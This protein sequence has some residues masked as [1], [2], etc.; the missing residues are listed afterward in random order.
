MKSLRIKI[1]FFMLLC[2]LVTSCIVSTL[3]IF[4]INYICNQDAVHIM[5]L[6]IQKKGSEINTLTSSIEQSVDILAHIAEAALTDLNTFQSSPT[7]VD[8][9]T[10]SLKPIAEQFAR[11]TKGASNV[12]IRYN[13]EFTEPT[14]GLFLVKNDNDTFEETIPVN[15]T[16]YSKTDT[17]HSAWYYIPTE[18][19]SATW[20]KPYYN[21]N[22]DAYYVTYVTP[23]YKNDTL[24]GVVG[25]DIDFSVIQEIID[26][27]PLYEGGYA[28]LINDDSTI[29]DHP[30]LEFN[31]SLDSEAYN[32]LNAALSESAATTTPTQYTYDNVNK[33][34]VYNPL[35]SGLSLVISA[36][37]ASIYQNLIKIILITLVATLIGIVF[38]FGV[39]LLLSFYIIKP[40]THLT[41]IIESTSQFDFKAL[42]TN[43]HLFKQ[44]DETGI[45]A[46]S[47]HKMRIS[48]HDIIR[49]IDKACHIITQNMVHLSSTTQDINTMC[50]DNS[51]TTE[52]LAAGMQ[53]TSATVDTIN[54]NV[55]HISTNTSHISILS[56]EG[57]SISEQVLER[58]NT[59]YDKTLKAQNKTK[60]VYTNVTH[61]SSVALEKIKSVDK[62]SQLTDTITNLSFQTGIL[63]INASIEAAHAGEAGK[64][65]AVVASEISTLAKQ[66]SEAVNDIST[67]IQEVQGAVKNMSTCLVDTS[68]FLEN[69]VLNDYS[70]FMQISK[71]YANDAHIFQDSM[72]TIST[73][74]TSLSETTSHISESLQGISATVSEST[75]GIMDIAEKTTSM[76]KIT[77]ESQSL[78]SEN[79]KRLLELENIVASFTLE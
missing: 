37:T 6:T 77:A 35:E 21:S 31:T 66:S 24:I 20:L 62:I 26:N 54:E 58:A 45:M 52:Q 3:S 32:S 48:L 46:R 27:T 63:A 44:K 25:M 72:Q 2:T 61:N 64:G 11:A 29:A 68:S 19:K 12:Y 79:Q 8:N 1:V 40:I 60:E 59:L 39:S 36:P 13:P 38:A 28:F 17:E 34:L 49:T 71:Q 67:I 76:V 41:T 4:N 14:S 56:Q 51:A 33:L 70:D 43:N 15:F 73:G 16:L 78:A 18:S 22:L 47:I 75:K 9:Y 55:K 5:N 23:F 50:M 65:F 57:Y 10:S 69:V 30:T 53:E 74:I 7:F 42:A